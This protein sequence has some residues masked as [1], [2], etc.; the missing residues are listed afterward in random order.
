MEIARL[1]HDIRLQRKDLEEA[2]RFLESEGE[3]TGAAAEA[4]EVHPLQVQI[5]FLTGFQPTPEFQDYHVDVL[6]FMV[7]LGNQIKDEIDT[8]KQVA[9]DT[10]A[11]AE[12]QTV[13]DIILDN[14]AD[15]IEASSSSQTEAQVRARLSALGPVTYKGMDIPSKFGVIYFFVK[16]YFHFGRTE[17]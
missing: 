9:A 14:L 17:Y 8:L 1:R 10:E 16:N 6:N 5:D 4:G 7:D 11:N 15:S 13:P 2:K 12:I 3:G